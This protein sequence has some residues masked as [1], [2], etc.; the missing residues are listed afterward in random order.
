[1]MVVVAFVAQQG[2]LLQGFIHWEAVG[3]ALAMSGDKNRLLCDD[4][5]FDWMLNSAGKSGQS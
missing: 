2:S 5:K 3:L 4:K 1:M